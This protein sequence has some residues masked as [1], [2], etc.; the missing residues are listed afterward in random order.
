MSE[1]EIV[2]LVASVSGTAEM[3]A[4]EVGEKLAELGL[5]H[6]VVGMQKA[7]AKMLDRR[8]T[9]II[10]SSTHGT[11]DVPE[12]G[13]PFYTLLTET[14]PDLSHA[15]YGVIALGDMSYSATFCGGGAK[16]DE[17]FHELGAKRLV[18]R[19]EHDSRSSA[20]GFPEEAALK[21]LDGWLAAHREFA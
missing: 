20:S 6:R 16:F 13:A 14:R 10:C 17:I 4:D 2:V 19:I 5:P 18:P 11:G 12:N 9:F 21:W 3:V 1:D 15:R 8:S 7:S